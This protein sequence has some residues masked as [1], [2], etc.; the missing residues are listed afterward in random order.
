MMSALMLFNIWKA[1]WTKQ[2]TFD[3]LPSGLKWM[4]Q[5]EY[6]VKW[7]AIKLSQLLKSDLT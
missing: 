5:N 2:N 7:S 4:K 1:T 3:G 6:T